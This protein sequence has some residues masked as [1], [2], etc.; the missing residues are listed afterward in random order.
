VKTHTVRLHKHKRSLTREH[1]GPG[2]LWGGVNFPHMSPPNAV[3]RIGSY[4]SAD[5]TLRF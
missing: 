3:P 4:N 5:N 2:S 1:T